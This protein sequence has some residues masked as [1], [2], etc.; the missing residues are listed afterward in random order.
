MGTERSSLP[1]IRALGQHIIASISCFTA[2]TFFTSVLEQ[3][4]AI[5]PSH[6]R[7]RS[8]PRGIREWDPAVRAAGNGQREVEAERYPCEVSSRSSS[9]ARSSRHHLLDRKSTRLNSSH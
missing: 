6:N 9:P 8:T 5:R 1:E 2:L 7:F 4:T 3:L